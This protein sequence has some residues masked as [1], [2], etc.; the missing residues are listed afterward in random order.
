M[1]ATSLAILAVISGKT[2]QFKLLALK[3]AEK[4]SKEAGNKIPVVGWLS[5]Y[6]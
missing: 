1:A 6:T 2:I 3:A 5:M 4:K